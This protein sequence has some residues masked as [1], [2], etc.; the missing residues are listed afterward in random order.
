MI[1]CTSRLPMLYI[2]DLQQ[3]IYIVDYRENAGG[4]VINVRSHLSGLCIDVN[5]LTNNEPTSLLGTV[6]FNGSDIQYN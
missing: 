5:R 1:V 4:D 6:S 3:Y 2:W